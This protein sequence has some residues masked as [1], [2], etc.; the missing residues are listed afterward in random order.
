MPSAR[1]LM[2]FAFFLLVEILALV[3]ISSIELLPSHM[4]DRLSKVTKPD[5]SASHG[6]LPCE[7]AAPV[8]PVK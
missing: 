8:V 1:D 5:A 2:V 3:L 4:T 7:G 6:S